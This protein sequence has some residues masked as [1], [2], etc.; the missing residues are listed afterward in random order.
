VDERI[1]E[2][3][4]FNSF[5]SNHYRGLGYVAWTTLNH[6]GNLGHNMNQQPMETQDK[7]PNNIPDRVATENKDRL[8]EAVDTLNQAMELIT[9]DPYSKITLPTESPQMP[10]K[11][12]INIFPKDDSTVNITGEGKEQNNL[13]MLMEQGQKK[14]K[15]L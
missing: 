1:F 10:Q 14:N 4:L 11:G 5:F 2:G 13:P 7:V 3:S 8:T 9:I 15:V 12:T 6:G